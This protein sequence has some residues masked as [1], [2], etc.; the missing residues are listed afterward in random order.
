VKVHCEVTPEDIAQGIP[1]SSI[2]CPNAISLSRHFPKKVVN[3]HKSRILVYH[4]L[5]PW[6]SLSPNGDA[7]EDKPKKETYSL[8]KRAWINA[9]LCIF[10]CDNVPLEVQKSIDD[11]DKTG[12]MEP[13]SFDVEFEQLQG[14][15]DAK[16]VE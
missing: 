1:Q 3:V 14:D 11:F 2:R 5:P 7:V 13:L 12:K 8:A 6:A 4:S 15:G 9:Q 16:V 10:A